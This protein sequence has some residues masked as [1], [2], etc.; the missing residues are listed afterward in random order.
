[1]KSWIRAGL[2]AALVAAVPV[3]PLAAGAKYT[4]QGFAFDAQEKPQ[5]VVVRPSLFMGTL[6]SAN[7]QIEDPE[8]LAQAHSN[9]QEALKRHPA[10]KTAQLRFDDWNDPQNKPL[11]EGFWKTTQ[12]IQSDIVFKVPQGSFPIAPGEDWQKRFKGLPKGPH[13]YALPMSAVEEIRQTYGAAD[14]ALLIKMHDAYTT[15]GAKLARLLGGM[16]N[17]MSDGVNTMAPPP[18]FGF[19]MLVDLRDGK[20]VWFFADGAFGGDLR[21]AASADKRVAQMLTKWPSAN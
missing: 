20:V 11:S 7:R 21:K 16:G 10:A 13:A 6:D 17:V 15:D 14:F 9:L 19:S 3:L 12:F 8:W 5:V 18:H 4:A 1:M 2:A